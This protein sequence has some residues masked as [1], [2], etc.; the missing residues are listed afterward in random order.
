MDPPPQE[1]KR[2]LSPQKRPHHLNS[3]LSEFKTD[4]VSPRHTKES[5]VQKVGEDGTNEQDEGGKQKLFD[6]SIHTPVTI[7]SCHRTPEYQLLPK[8][9]QIMQD[10]SQP[11]V[12]CPC[13][14]TNPGGTGERQVRDIDQIVSSDAVTPSGSGAGRGRNA[15]VHVNDGQR[16]RPEV[17]SRAHSHPRTQPHQPHAPQPSLVSQQTQNLDSSLRYKQLVSGLES[18]AGEAPPAYESVAGSL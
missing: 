16:E 7:L 2:I 15:P 17:S 4:L 6:I 11:Q 3:R 10:G 9:S 14:S 18:E 13:D 5:K 8:Y 12:A 1:S